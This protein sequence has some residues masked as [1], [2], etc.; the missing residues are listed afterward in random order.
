V[1]AGIVGDNA[2]TVM[3][4]LAEKLLSEAGMNA[5]DVS[6]KGSI[7]CEKGGESIKRGSDE[8]IIKAAAPQLI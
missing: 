1:S 5:S 7:T 4:N 3:E 6:G 8:L 2:G